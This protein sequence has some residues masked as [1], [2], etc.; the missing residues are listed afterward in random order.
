MSVAEDFPDNVWP[1]HPVEPPPEDE[2]EPPYDL[3]DA[4][5]AKPRK[6]DPF[7]NAWT[8][9]RLMAEEFPAPRWAVPG[10]IPEGLTILAGAPKA[11]KSWLAL[12]LALAIAGGT[13]VL[14]EIQ[15]DAGE[16][17]YLALEDTPRRLQSRMSKILGD[18]PAPAGLTLLTEFPTLPSGGAEAVGGWLE[19]RP[20]A[21]L[22]VIDVFAKVRGT[23]RP[24]S[25]PMTPTTRQWGGQRP[26]PTSSGLLSSS[27]TTC[28]RW[29]PTTSPQNC[30][31]PTESPDRPTRSWP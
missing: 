14:G 19:A 24:A 20:N 29:P 1:L 10:L 25:I 3:V 21:R 17:L 2:W 13:S 4:V 30:P 7:A 12:N 9:D 5:P 16:A 15:V 22:V 6:A 18:Q 26:S 11:G 31:A 27:C 8:A 28:G 23:T